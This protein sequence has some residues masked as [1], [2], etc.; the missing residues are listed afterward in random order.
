MAD[1][2]HHRKKKRKTFKIIVI[3][4]VII[5]TFHSTTCIVSYQ[6]DISRSYYFVSRGP[7]DSLRYVRPISAIT[8]SDMDD[9]CM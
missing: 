5:D 6:L 1:N 3:F 2:G 9:I 8:L 4:E 7:G